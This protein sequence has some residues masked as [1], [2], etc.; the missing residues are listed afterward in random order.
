MGPHR[1]S[2]AAAVAVLL[3]GQCATAAP[4]TSPPLIST[5]VVAAVAHGRARVLVELRLSGGARAEGELHDRDAIS[6]QRSGIAALQQAVIARLQG[7][8]AVVLHQYASVP[9]LALEIGPSALRAI[10]RMP[11]VIRVVEDSALR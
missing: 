4:G 5:T 1:R 8:D 2:R 3:V 11:E 6:A 7:T 9:F 10:E